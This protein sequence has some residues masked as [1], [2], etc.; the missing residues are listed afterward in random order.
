MEYLDTIAQVLA[1]TIRLTIPLLFACLAGLYS[2]RS[3]VFDIGLEGK[4]LVAAFAAGAAAAVGHSP[5]LGLLAGVGTSVAFALLHGFAVITI[6]A[7]RSC[8][9]LPSISLRLGCRRSS[10]APG[11]ASAGRRRSCSLKSAFSN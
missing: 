7:I 8:R 6:A 11:S 9:A 10:A 5:W 2:E 4:M 3:G 1:S